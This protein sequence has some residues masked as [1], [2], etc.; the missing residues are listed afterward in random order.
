M[1]QHTMSAKPKQPLD[2]SQRLFCNDQNA[3]LRLLAPAGSGKTTSLLWRCATLAEQAN[4]ETSRFLIFTFT[5]AARDELRERLRDNSDFA[6]VAPNTEI[7]TLNAWGQRR[8]KARAY[9]MQLLVSRDKRYWAMTNSLQ[10]IWMHYPWLKDALT[11]SRRKTRAARELMDLSDTLKSLGF[12][13][14][15]H[16]TPEDFS[17]HA[18]WLINNGMGAKLYGLIRVLI[19]L[20]V[21][22]PMLK[23]LEETLG[24]V[25]EHYMSFWSKACVHLYQSAT[26]TLEDQKY[27]ALMDIESNLKD[28]KFTTGIHRFH[29]VMVD[30]FQ[31]INPLDLNLL[32]AV[33][34][35]NKCGLCIVG[36]D[37]Q[38]IYEW[39]GATPEFILNPNDHIA[40][41]FKTHIL[42]VNYRS[43]ANIVEHSRKLIAHNKRRVSKDVRA[44]SKK[45]AL[46]S[47]FTSPSIEQSITYVAERVKELLGDPSIKNVAL[48]SRKRSQIIPYQIV[49]AGE[50]IPFYAAED[51]QVLMSS[52]FEELKAILL[53][54]AQS[55]QPFPFGPDP[56]EAML[57][58]CDK[59]KRYPLSKT[60][61]QHLKTYLLSKRPKTVLQALEYLYSYDGPLK[62]ASN[63]GAMAQVFFFAIRD[64]L[65]SKTVSEALQSI[66]TH[67]SGLQKDYGKSLDDIFYAD[68]PFLYL[69]D[70][71]ARYG[72]D[73]VRF[74]EDIEKAI[75]TLAKIPTADDD[76]SDGSD[77]RNRPLH[78]MT[79][80]RA[81]GKE[82]DAVVILDCNQGIWP[83]KLAQT[84]EELE[85]ERRLFYVAFTRV[86]KELILVVNER[87]LGESV[88][89]SPF[90]AE[91]GL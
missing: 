84:E 85:A 5:R 4:R 61:R 3:Y 24:E 10:P 37:D 23:T 60:D 73:F 8:I 64:L 43:P 55:N 14:D 65:I 91:S 21:I 81:K 83:S 90:I 1:D 79:A 69:A 72:E 89:P 54:K 29:H 13:H 71:A 42:Q 2:D 9:N 51:L 26:F 50:E 52:A 77:G 46:I 38:A 82:F 66:S 20:E 76:E 59:V 6:N 28:G 16:N 12:R 22:S 17:A 47:I 53:L 30:E 67:F 11:D 56:V 86:R 45:S 75:S 34:A 33:A 7:T 39:R 36:D 87:I 32:K 80:L 15:E 18:Y 19:D 25:F 78:L 63:G 31:D 57:R 41:G 35:Y 70:Y 62:G 68:P 74:Y 49:F 48:I 40:S 44:S 58:I 88:S 27:W